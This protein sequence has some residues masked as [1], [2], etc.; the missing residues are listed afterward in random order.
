MKNDFSYDYCIFCKKMLHNQQF[1]ALQESHLLPNLALIFSKITHRTT[2]KI[3]CAA[4][5]PNDALCTISAHDL[6]PKLITFLSW[7]TNLNTDAIFDHLD[8]RFSSLVPSATSIW[9]VLRKNRV[10]YKGG[11]YPRSW[12]SNFELTFCPW[13]FSTTLITNLTVK[14]RSDHL[15]RLFREV[16]IR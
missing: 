2:M 4:N 12:P 10:F 6:T 16:R 11:W 8:N 1:S 9:H 15:F 14:T 5:N 13:G 3:S 7:Q